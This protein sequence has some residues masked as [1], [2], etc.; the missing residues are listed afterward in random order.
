M[1]EKKSAHKFR[2]LYSF[3]RVSRATSIFISFSCRKKL[4]KHENVWKLIGNYA[5]KS[6]FRKTEKN[7]QQRT[8][9]R[10]FMSRSVFLAKKFL[11]NEHQIP[12]FSFNPIAWAHLCVGEWEEKR[13]CICDCMCASIWPNQMHFI[14]LMWFLMIFFHFLFLQW[15]RWNIVKWQLRQAALETDDTYR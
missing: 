3:V 14:F 11:R 8:S 10:K 4:A 6:T 7:A 13:F 5:V 1:H 2:T 12:L 9:K 15:T